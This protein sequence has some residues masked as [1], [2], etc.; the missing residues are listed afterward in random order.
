MCI[1]LGG[2]NFGES[3]N[4]NDFK[5]RITKNRIE[6]FEGS[7]VPAYI[8]NN[9]MNIEQAVVKGEL[10]IGDSKKETLSGVFVWKVRDNNHLGLSWVKKA[11]V[12]E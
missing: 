2:R 12:N 6:F 9:A 1:E 5:L 4:G 8:S 10:Q 3:E 7:D 11:G